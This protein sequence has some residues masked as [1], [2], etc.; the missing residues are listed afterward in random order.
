[1]AGKF[2]FPFHL[3]WNGRYLFISIYFHLCLYYMCTMYFRGTVC[4]WIFWVHFLCLFSLWQN[5]LWFVAFSLP[6]YPLSDQHGHAQT[7]F[8]AHSCWFSWLA[9]A[10]KKE[11]NKKNLSV[12]VALLTKFPMDSHLFEQCSR[13]A[14]FIDYKV[15]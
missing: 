9:S 15:S 1:M 8:V 2:P 7:H 5:N 11:D 6:L 4:A 13:N 3:V 12:L 14:Y 10:Q